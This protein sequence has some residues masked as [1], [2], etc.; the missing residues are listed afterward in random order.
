VALRV[1]SKD[2]LLGWHRVLAA[3]GWVAPAWPVEWGGTTWSVVQRYI[4]E[5]ECGYAAAPPLIPFGLA[6]CAS[7]LFK[8]GT[9][10][11]KRRFLPRIY[12][13]EDFWCQGYSEPGSGSDL[14]SLRTAAVRRGEH[15][16]VT[17][18]KT[19]T[20]LTWPTGSS[21]WCAPT[22]HSTKTGGFRSC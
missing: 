21:A 13:G 14:A 4:F 5:E 16:V 19:W 15:Y 20:T 1:L 6:M 11:Q 8:F 10:A 17:G 12:R 22:P 2:D 3:K 18:Q 7:V 9:D